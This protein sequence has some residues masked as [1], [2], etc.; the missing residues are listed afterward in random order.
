MV[1]PTR[2]VIGFSFSSAFA[3]GPWPWPCVRLSGGVGRVAGR[4]HPHRRPLCCWSA[5]CAFLCLVIVQVGVV[6]LLPAGRHRCRGPSSWSL[7]TVVLLGRRRYPASWPSAAVGVWLP[8]VVGRRPSSFFSFSHLMPA[9][10][11]G[12][13]RGWRRESGSEPL[14]PPSL[15]PDP[16]TPPPFPC[17]PVYV[18]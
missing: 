10:G 2:A 17:R 12:W 8:V 16:W 1:P 13:L 3:L 4:R 5:V 11:P 7:A 18:V 6:V 14:S 9:L 15:L